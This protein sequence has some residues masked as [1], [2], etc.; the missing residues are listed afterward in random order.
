MNLFHEGISERKIILG[1][2]IRVNENV[3]DEKADRMISWIK[4]KCPA[5]LRKVKIA[6]QITF[7]EER[8]AMW[9]F[10]FIEKNNIKNL[11]VK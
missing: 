8:Y 5:R 6:A 10:F 2:I 3:G 4:K 9:C 11:F 7:H 1:V